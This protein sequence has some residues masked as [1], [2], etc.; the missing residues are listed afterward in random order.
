MI[1]EVS[2]AL[3]AAELLAALCTG[4]DTECILGLYAG[5]GHYDQGWHATGTI[6]LVLRA[7][8]ET[9]VA[10]THFNS[11]D[12]KSRW[13]RVKRIIPIHA[14][15]HIIVDHKTARKPWQRG[16]ESAKQTN[17]PGWYGHW[18][19]RMW[20]MRGGEQPPAVLFFFDVFTTDGKSM[21]S[22]EG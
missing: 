14:G 11:P 9:A 2:I 19:P 18:W 21:I 17:Q 10:A 8:H 12:G 22:A 7:R 16:K 15:T 6:D 4:I 13:E 5:R 20:A 3:A 1:S